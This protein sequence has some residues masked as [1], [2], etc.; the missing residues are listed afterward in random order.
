MKRWVTLL[1]G[2]RVKGFIGN[3]ITLGGFVHSGR[4]ETEAVW[5]C[6]L[7]AGEEEF[8]VAV[9]ISSDKVR[10]ITRVRALRL[11]SLLLPRTTYSIPP[12]RI[13]TEP[14]APYSRLSSQ[15]F[16]PFAFYAPKMQVHFGPSILCGQ[17]AAAGDDLHQ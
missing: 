1:D 15:E 7:M 4:I 12:S 13:S 3:I 10:R 8:P 16:C 17:L 14:V 6:F 2:M 9:S 5:W 11:F